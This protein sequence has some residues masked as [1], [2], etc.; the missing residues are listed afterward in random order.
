MRTRGAVTVVMLAC[1]L[2]RNA[3]H[4][5]I[6]HGGASQ[7]GRFRTA[8]TGQ[9]ETLT[10]PE[11]EPIRDAKVSAD[12]PVIGLDVNGDARC[13]PI[14]QMWYHHIVND[15]IGGQKLAVTYCIMA[16]TALTYRLDDLTSGL[17]VGGL[18]AGVLCMR[19]QGTDLLYPQ[20]AAVP[21]PDNLS[22]GKLV[23][24]P[25]P[26]ITTFGAWKKVHPESKVLKPVPKHGIRYEAYEKKPKGYNTNPLMNETV[27]RRD[28]RLDAGREVFGLSLGKDSVA[29]PL[30][31]LRK[32]G[33]AE[34]N[35]GA[36]TVRVVWDKDLETAR[37]EPPFDGIA[38]RAFWYAWCSFYPETKLPMADKPGAAK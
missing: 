28:D 34:A 20:I 36:K 23:P 9:F 1:A 4:A 35:L 6:R 24:G 16:N 19:R 11:Y 17:E 22:E 31:E 27:T 26:V 13:F 10:R 7:Y 25:A 37:V 33:G 5:E 32:A 14:S 30:D 12:T 29:Y 38:T 3:V 21:V 15:E 18:Y 8:P 2:G